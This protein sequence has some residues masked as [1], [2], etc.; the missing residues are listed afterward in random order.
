[1]DDAVQRASIDDAAQYCDFLFQHLH[2]FI[3]LNRNIL[4]DVLIGDL[5]KVQAKASDLLRRH[6]TLLRSYAWRV[7]PYP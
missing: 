2:G 7:K 5:R 3:G 1:M 4:S 6:R